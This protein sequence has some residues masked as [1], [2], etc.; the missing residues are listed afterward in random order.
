MAVP[1]TISVTAMPSQEADA[2]DLESE[3]GC[4]RVDQEAQPTHD[5][6]VDVSLVQ[7]L[8]GRGEY[9]D[10]PARPYGWRH[11][12]QRGAEVRPGPLVHGETFGKLP[13]GLLRNPLPRLVRGKECA[14]VL[15]DCSG[16]RDRCHLLPNDTA[17]CGGTVAVPKRQ[18]HSVLC[19]M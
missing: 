15:A 5:V 6:L 4:D 18:R 10:E 11:V 2:R 8:D 13:F 19:E 16:V 17:P 3:I 1:T 14:R 7:D 9:V 12:A